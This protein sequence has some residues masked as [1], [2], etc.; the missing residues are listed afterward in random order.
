MRAA[1]IVVATIAVAAAI[2]VWAIWPAATDRA[3]A[4]DA[5]L[6][7]AGAGL[8]R[9]HCASCH[10]AKLEGEP[11]WRTRK[12]NGRL[13]APPHDATGHTWHHSDA[14]LFGLTKIGVKPPLA[15]PGYRSDMNGFGE[16]LSD[17]EIWAVLAYIKSAWPPDVR[18]HQE[19]VDRTARR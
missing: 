12:P 4:G 1:V 7:A 19:R 8:Y 14:Q 2:T 6:V 18:T 16:I 3:D 17:R 15:P 11:D 10:G 13:P 5:R 9:Q